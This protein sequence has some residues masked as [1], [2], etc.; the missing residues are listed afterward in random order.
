MPRSKSSIHNAICHC[1]AAI[2]ETSGVFIEQSDT[3]N[4]ATA[5]QLVFVIRIY[6]L[7]QS[8]NLTD[9]RQ[10][11]SHGYKYGL[12]YNFLCCNYGHYGQ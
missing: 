11:F 5:T 9:I 12:L 6:I 1:C 4:R 10:T 3:V 8:C 2:S 7:E